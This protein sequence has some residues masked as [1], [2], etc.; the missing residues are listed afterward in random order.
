MLLEDVDGKELVFGK[1]A[2][3]EIMNLDAHTPLTQPEQDFIQT[4]FQQLLGK[5][6]TP[7]SQDRSIYSLALENADKYKTE[8]EALLSELRKHFF[9][10]PCALGCDP[11]E[12]LPGELISLDYTMKMYNE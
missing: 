6:Y 8:N 11:L 4:H 5:I 10:V 12:V 1:Y 3:E 9:V 7:F 2:P